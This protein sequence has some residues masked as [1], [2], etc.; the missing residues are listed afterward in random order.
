MFQKERQTISADEV[1]R[2]LAN[3]EDIK[4]NQCTITGV[5]DVNRLLV[6]SSPFD[7]EK[8]PLERQDGTV[9]ITLTQSLVFDKCTFEENVVFSGPWSE[10]D[11]IKVIFQQDAIFNSSHFKA[12]TRFRC[13]VFEKAG[14]FDGCIFD[15]VVTFKNAVFGGAAKFRTVGFNGYA[16]MGS[17]VFRAPARFDNTHFARGLDFSDV[18]FEKGAQFRGVYCSA[19][20][21][22][23]Y[24]RIHFALSHLG[25]D[26]DFW[27]F[28][29][30]TAQDAGHYRLAGECF[31]NECCA[32][33]WRKLWGSNYDSLSIGKKVGRYFGAIRLI[34]ELVFGKWLF[35]Y[36]ERPARILAVAAGIIL[37]CALAF[38]QPDALMFDGS[39]AEPSFLQ[40]VYFSIVTFS[41][42]G[43][44]ELYPQ[45]GSIFRI[46]AMAEAISGVCLTALFIVCLAKR[47][48]RN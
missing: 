7:I 6:E 10:P 5:L 40:S 35:G 23:K 41:T 26:E 27:R 31:Y 37:L 4:L 15:G 39:T 19:R 32:A 16:L 14:S 18:R 9:T 43:Y 22:P 1:L 45:P 13:A 38:N 20:A 44:G 34:P 25:D 28:V 46:I 3:G 2:N 36:G 24:D 42:L 33:L 48:S 11:S 21:I 30:Q 29:K 12:Q 17:I 47:F 8:L